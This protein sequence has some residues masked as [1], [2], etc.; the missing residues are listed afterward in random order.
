MLLHTFHHHLQPD[1]RRSRYSEMDG[2]NTL[3]VK[4]FFNPNSLCTLGHGQI[5]HFLSLENTFFFTASDWD[6]WNQTRLI[7][8]LSCPLW[9]SEEKR[10][11]RG[12]DW[13]HSFPVLRGAQRDGN[14][15]QW[16][17]QERSWKRKGEKELAVFAP[18][19][20]LFGL[21][22]QSVWSVS[23][24]SVLCQAS[25]RWLFRPLFTSGPPGGFQTQRH[26]Q[27]ISGKGS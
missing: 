6:P 15:R 1:C 23:W 9:V 12:P 22:I 5:S 4:S 20:C 13:N 16:K 26:W 18:P 24:P 21:Y 7:S 8:H 2:C 3:T 10:C 17:Q 11:Q 25:Q 19:G 27:S 14:M